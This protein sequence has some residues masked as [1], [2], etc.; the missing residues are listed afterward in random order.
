MYVLMDIQKKYEF[1]IS[2]YQ[3]GILLTL[4]ENQKIT[5]KE[6]VDGTKIPIE[7]LR[8]NLVQLINPT[9]SK[10]KFS[11]ILSHNG[12]KMKKEN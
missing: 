3:L 8:V 6:L 10:D 4:N 2:S 7:N 11:N 5:F 9:D 12:K 1:V